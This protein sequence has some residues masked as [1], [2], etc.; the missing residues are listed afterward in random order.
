M[1]AIIVGAGIVGIT[2]ARMLARRGY[3]VT[4]VDAHE[5]PGLETS[6]ANAGQRSYG[7][8]SPWAAPDLI[9]VGLKGLI[10][11]QG[12]LKMHMP[13]AP[14][15]LGFLL[16]T[17]RYA[18]ENGRYE[19]SNR[20][21]LQLGQVSRDA[22]N[23]IDHE[24]PEGFD[25]HHQGLLEISR[26][27]VEYAGLQNKAKALL[28][29]QIEHQWLNASSVNHQE[30]A[31]AATGNL[32]PSLL[33][34]GDGTGDCHRLSQLL[35]AQCRE[36]GVRFLF[37]TTVTQWE[38]DGYALEGAHVCDGSSNWLEAADT[39][40][41]CAGCAS[42]DLTR[43]LGVKLP[44]YPVKGYSLT[45]P[46]DNPDKA[47]RSTVV[48]LD[49]NVAITR[50]GDRMRVTGFAELTGFNRRIPESRLQVLQEAVHERF[51][52]AAD[53]RHAEPWTGFRPMLP[54][55]PPA[56]GAGNLR[57]LW[58]NTGHGTFGWTL[59]AGSA[60]LLGRMMHGE[61]APID[62]RAFDPRRFS[63]VTR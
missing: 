14:R 46:L 60:E 50:L 21:L 41:V 7:H 47:P 54:D 25:G 30:P 52:G 18:W 2:T 49:N 40:V 44:V 26:D 55:G 61:A 56:L 62:V 12:P 33:I 63:N 5:G 31:L 1:R 45:A 29:Q 43:P 57:N 19:A 10:R 42:R 34:N 24:L 4:V 53:L 27:P 58:L 32:Q 17:L 20:A 38:H 9:A 15:T 51:P 3:T 59:S 22:F 13:P 6:Y 35:M 28:E 37:N 8:V 11:R 39:T 48:D 16:Q 36:A 23:A